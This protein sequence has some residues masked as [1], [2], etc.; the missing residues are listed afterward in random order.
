MNGRIDEKNLSQEV[1]DE[2]EK[3]LI[4]YWELLF[5]YIL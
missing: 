2:D 4:N 1:L 3:Q 5:F